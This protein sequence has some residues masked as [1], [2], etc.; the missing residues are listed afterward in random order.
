MKRQCT[1]KISVIQKGKLVT[2]MITIC[3]S[4]T[5]LVM[6]QSTIEEREQKAQRVNKLYKMAEQAYRD[7]DIT[8]A[9]DTLQIVLAEKPGHAHS[10]ALLRKIQLN[11]GRLELVKKKNKFNAVII[12]EVAY[13]GIDLRQAL[14]ILNQQVMTASGKKVIPNF[15]LRDPSKYLGNERIELQLNNVPAGVVLDHLMK[16]TGTSAKF[17]K[18]SITISPRSSAY[19]NKA[20]QAPIKEAELE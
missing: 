4:A 1:R 12:K 3:L 19:K 5:Q 11:G 2:F 17:G 13:N 9:R 14:K 16:K 20:K 10:I 18:Y 8:V 7:N 6:A 15:V